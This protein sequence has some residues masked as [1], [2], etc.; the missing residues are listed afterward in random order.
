MNNGS[1]V[2]K[3][4]QDGMLSHLEHAGAEIRNARPIPAPPLGFWIYLTYRGQR[5][6]LQLESLDNHLVS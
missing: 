3:T 4:L 6:K 5:F 1:R 2:L